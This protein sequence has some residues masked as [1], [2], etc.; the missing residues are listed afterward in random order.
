[1][2][3]IAMV[4]TINRLQS[5]VAKAVVQTVTLWRRL[6]RGVGQTMRASVAVASMSMLAI[7][8]ADAQV[9]ADIHVFYTGQALAFYNNNV[10][11]L[12]TRVD[13]MITWA[14]SAY[15]NSNVNVRLRRIALNTFDCTDCNTVTRLGLT[16]FTHSGQV[17]SRRNTS[18]ADFAVL[19][20]LSSPT[21]SGLAWYPRSMESTGCYNRVCSSTIKP[22]N[23]VTSFSVVALNDLAY[24]LAHEIGHNM[25]LAHSPAQNEQGFP[26][27]WGRGFGIN[28]TF[29]TTMAYRS[30]YNWAPMITH[31]SNPSITFQGNPTGQVNN[32]DA[33]R[34]LNV[35]AG[36]FGRFSDCYF[37]LAS[38]CPWPGCT[39]G[40]TCR[41][42]TSRT[43]PAPYCSSET[44][45][46][47]GTV[48][49]SSDSHRR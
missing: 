11:T 39:A 13:Q 30:A 2:G 38:S 29:V 7:P 45:C 26:Y 24:V 17:R 42:G 36:Y 5:G 47:G 31:F 6:R 28:G 25:G 44:S 16:A 40:T 32:A 9:T 43:S 4:N 23:G 15:A 41:I 48:S 46:G 19:F 27:A 49:A 22:P 35:G 34:A 1:M 33:A 12:L 14:N 8:V 20:T 18:R 3:S 21:I 10:N 37:E